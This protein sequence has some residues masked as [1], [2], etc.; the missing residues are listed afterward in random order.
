MI[1]RILRLSAIEYID[2]A[3]AGTSAYEELDGDIVDFYLGFDGREWAE[4]YTGA[5]DEVYLLTRALSS[6]EVQQAMDG[7]D[8]SVKPAGKLAGTWGDL[9][10]AE[11]R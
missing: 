4:A 9:K 2:G 5:I 6:E 7:I 10:R 3:E 1:G 11:Y 8:L